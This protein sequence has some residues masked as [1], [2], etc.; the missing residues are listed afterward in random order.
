MVHSEDRLEVCIEKWRQFDTFVCNH[1]KEAQEYRDRVKTLELQQQL[2]EKSVSRNA[3]VGGII[4][5]LIG[6][7]ASP[8]IIHIVELLIKVG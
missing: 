1:N 2:L 6:S 4:G 8:A 5:A 3:I 7:G